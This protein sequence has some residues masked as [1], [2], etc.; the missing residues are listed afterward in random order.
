LSIEQQ[1]Q[2]TYD[3]LGLQVAVH[4]IHVLPGEEG[5]GLQQLP[6]ELPDQVQG[7]PFEPVWREG[8]RDALTLGSTDG[9]ME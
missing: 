7:H 5:Q 2:Q 8:G 3:V 4:D 9:W 1:Q 6:R